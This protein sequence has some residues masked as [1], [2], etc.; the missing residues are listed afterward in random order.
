MKTTSKNLSR[1]NFIKISGMSGAVLALGY[2][3]PAAGKEPEILNK[4]TAESR[5]IEMNAWISIDTSGKVTIINHR[6]EMGQGS[7][8]AVPQIIAEEL[9]VDLNQVNIIFAEGNS[10]IYGS[11]VTGGSSTVRG[12]YT[13]LLQL[14]ASAREMLIQTAAKRWGVEPS[15]CFAENGQ[16]K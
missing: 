8:Q 9:E 2:Y 4:V 5:G 1:R 14:S 10:S 7:F 15:T 13:R 11:Q 16:V 3:L 12:T 6:A